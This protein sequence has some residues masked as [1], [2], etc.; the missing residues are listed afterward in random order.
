[1][2]PDVLLGV[3]AAFTE[4]PVRGGDYKNL[5]WHT[6]ADFIVLYLF[7]LYFPLLGF[8]VTFRDLFNKSSFKDFPVH[9][10]DVRI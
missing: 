1:M 4:P 10:A 7:Y 3:C 9:K 6:N 8:N 5:T 2:F